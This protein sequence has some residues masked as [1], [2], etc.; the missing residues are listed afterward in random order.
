MTFENR[1]ELSKASPILYTK[2]GDNC[3]YTYKLIYIVSA[4]ITS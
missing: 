4:H 2:K 3:I 1:I